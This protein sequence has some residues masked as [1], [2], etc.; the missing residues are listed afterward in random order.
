MKRGMN[1]ASR[2]C[3][4]REIARIFDAG[5]RLADGRMTLFAVPNGRSHSR[6]AVGVS[7][8][9]GNAVRRNRVKRLCRE[10][11]RLTRPDLPAG[12]DYMIIPRAGRTATLEGLQDALRKLAVRAAKQQDA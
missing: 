11:F 3:R 12:W 10:A 1:K 8:R 6:A 7:K 4:Q 9:H 2:V 5:V